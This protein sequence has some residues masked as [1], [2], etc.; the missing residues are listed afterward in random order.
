M[1]LDHQLYFSKDNYIIKLLIG[2]LVC[3]KHIIPFPG[4]YFY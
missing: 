4:A 2:V 3:E 1:L